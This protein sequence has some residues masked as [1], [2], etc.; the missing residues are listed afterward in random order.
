MIMTRDLENLGYIGRYCFRGMGNAEEVA[1]HGWAVAAFELCMC[2][3]NFSSNAC[4]A[5]F[6]QVNMRFRRWKARER[7]DMQHR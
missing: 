4:A 3:P 5:A 6:T 1:G 7:R 2:L